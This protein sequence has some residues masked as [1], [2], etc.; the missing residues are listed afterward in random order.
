MSLGLEALNCVLS[1]YSYSFLPKF[2][3][4]CALPLQ[5]SGG[6]NTVHWVSL[7]LLTERYSYVVFLLQAA[8]S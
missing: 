7:S 1:T 6:S 3:Q 4:P 2:A 8:F 5:C